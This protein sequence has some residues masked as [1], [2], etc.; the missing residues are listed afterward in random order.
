MAWSHAALAGLHFVS[1]GL[2]TYDRHG[3]QHQRET[4]GREGEET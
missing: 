4:I 3:L 2:I 1:S